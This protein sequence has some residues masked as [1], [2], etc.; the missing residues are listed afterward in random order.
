METLE[1]NLRYR[2]YEIIEV[3]ADGDLLSRAF[4][5]T[6]LSLIVI[7]VLALVLGT[8]DEIYQISP[9]FF[10]NIELVSVLIF[11]FEYLLRLWCCVENPRFAGA[12]K[13]RLKYIM[14]FMGLVDLVAILPFYLPFIA[15]HFTFFRVIRL[16]RIFRLFKLV[17]YSAALASLEIVLKKRKEELFSTLFVL[18]LL[19]L[20]V[21]S[22]MYYAENSAQPEAFSSIPKAMWWGVAT[23]TTVGYGDVY[24]ITAIGKIMGAF[25]A[26]LG[27]GLF[28][29][30]AG[31]IGA[32]YLDE[33]ESRKKKKTIQD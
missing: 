28:A 30:P 1:L 33:I 25:V 24:P 7:N 6:I 29:L 5:I 31:I 20:C 14:S 27:I 12:I 10:K 2:V 18:F 22:L 17:R 13:G 4:D 21:S 19:L 15:G 11:T 3:A 16:V 23:L 32:S 8:V 26:V 9:A